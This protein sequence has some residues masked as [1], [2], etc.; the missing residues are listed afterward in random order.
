MSISN[1]L[2]KLKILKEELCLF[3]RIQ[4]Y[5]PD[6]VVF[7]PASYRFTNFFIKQ[8]EQFPLCSYVIVQPFCQNS[9]QMAKKI[10]MFPLMHNV[11][12]KKSYPVHK[13]VPHTYCLP[14]PKPFPFSQP[15]FKQL[16]QTYP[17]PY[18][19]LKSNLVITQINPKKACQRKY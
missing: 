14:R 3:N 16:Q 9:R 8:Q 4:H 6:Y 13:V 1:T 2:K 10:I 17:T 5:K 19:R 15:K 7:I 11:C 18:I 12:I